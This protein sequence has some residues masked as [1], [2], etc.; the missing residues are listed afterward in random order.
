M[1][2]LIRITK[3]DTEQHRL[4]AIVSIQ[5]EQERVYF[6]RVRSHR[7]REGDVTKRETNVH[8]GA[9]RLCCRLFPNGGAEVAAF[10]FREEGSAEVYC[11]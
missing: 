2:A 6:C 7:V 5:Y 8:L 3:T 9:F 10:S 1:I 11:T 4:P